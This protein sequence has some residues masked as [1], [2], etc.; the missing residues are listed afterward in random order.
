M[1][2]KQGANN[3]H[4]TSLSSRVW[5]LNMNALNRQQSPLW[6]PTSASLVRNEFEVRTRSW[7]PPEPEEKF[8]NQD[9]ESA[10]NCPFPRSVFY[11]VH[12]T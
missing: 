7:I 4:S 9:G 1:N 8:L 6:L 12:D 10:I 3:S 2:L 5:G 11:R